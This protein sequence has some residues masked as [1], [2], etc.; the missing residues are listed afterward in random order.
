MELNSL[1]LKDFESWK[2]VNPDFI[3]MNYTTSI[4][5]QNNIPPNFLVFFSQL[6]FPDFLLENNMIFLK[7]NFRKKYLDRFLA[8][9]AIPKEIEY[10]LNLILISSFF[11]DGNEYIKHAIFI[12]NYMKIYVHEKLK[13]D[14]NDRNFFVEYTYDEEKGEVFF[15]FYQ[16]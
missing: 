3:P 10:W 13:K 15:S 16:I 1:V 8:E 12:A 9:E 5:D 7:N 14:F 11:P 4:I 2:K 6:F